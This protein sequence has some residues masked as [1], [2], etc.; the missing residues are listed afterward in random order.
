MPTLTFKQKD[1]LDRLFWTLVLAGVSFGTVY[2]ADVNELWGFALLAALQS[3]KN[4]AAQQIGDK[5]SSG[6]ANP[7]DAVSVEEIKALPAGDPDGVVRDPNLDREIEDV[8]DVA[9]DGQ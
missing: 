7:L 2:F 1:F 9:E 4:K 8:V 5:E 3:I 6:F